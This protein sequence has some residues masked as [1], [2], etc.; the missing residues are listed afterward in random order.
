MNIRIFLFSSI[1]V[2]AVFTAAA[3]KHPFIGMWQ[4]DME[5]TLENARKNPKFKQEDFEKMEQ[6][7]PP[8]KIE[9][10]V[11]EATGKDYATRES[12]REQ[13][14]QLRS[15]NEFFHLLM[16]HRKNRGEQ[17]VTRTIGDVFSKIGEPAVPFLFRKSVEYEETNDIKISP[18]G[19]ILTQYLRYDAV[20]FLVTKLENGTLAEKKL[21]AWALSSICRW[22][23]PKVAEPHKLAEALYQTVTSTT[24]PY[25]LEFS[26]KALGSFDT[27]ESVSFLVKLLSE[28]QH[29]KQACE[30]LSRL[31]SDAFEAVGP[32]RQLI[33]TGE[34]PMEAIDAL[35][36]AGG[37]DQV[38]FL[39]EKVND[40]AQDD[41]KARTRLARAIRNHPHPAAI[42][43]ME[44]I[45]SNPDYPSGGKIFAAIFFSN[46]DH[47]ASISNLGKS[48]ELPYPEESGEGDGQLASPSN[49]IHSGPVADI[50]ELAV[51][52]LADKGATAY[53]DRMLFLLKTDP[54]INVRTAV[55]EAIADRQVPGESVTKELAQ[56][57]FV[58]GSDYTK[59]GYRERTLPDAT[60]TALSQ[61]GTRES[62]EALY[63]GM[64]GSP[65]AKYCVG[66]WVSAPEKS[67][68]ERFLELYRKSPVKPE[69]ASSILL[70]QLKRHGNDYVLSGT[71]A[72]EK[73]T[74]FMKSVDPDRVEKEMALN[75]EGSFTLQR[76]I[77]FFTIPFALFHTAENVVV[78]Q[79]TDM[80]WFPM[81]R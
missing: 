15:D 57:L 23:D 7:L 34:Y 21:S 72:V 33:E 53:F 49:P 74:S 29:V 18:A 45:L 50:R 64:L 80:G 61:I 79:E 31:K 42:P 51:R 71:R 1:F 30:G 19:G 46:L 52:Y 8:E 40:W 9:A 69:Y 60:V 4:P 37:K 11:V 3:S 32:L 54:S 14:S 12:A 39:V 65:S 43:L 44:E 41:E 56:L 25:V 17:F 62:L 66:Y 47:E 59:W 75:R 2:T 55:V 10:L 20:P 6:I 24:D 63:Q 70:A 38:P 16:L 73:M 26:R 78:Y 35:V 77:N 48:L 76:H 22:R 5:A 67:V 28:P 81:Q 13:L 68:F 36:N 58:R 27:P